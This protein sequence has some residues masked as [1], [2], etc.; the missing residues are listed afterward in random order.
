MFEPMWAYTDH[1]SIAAAAV[2]LF[3]DP[4]RRGCRCSGRMTSA[5]ASC[6]SRTDVIV[7]PMLGV[8]PFRKQVLAGLADDRPI[9]VGPLRRDGQGHDRSDRQRSTTPRFPAR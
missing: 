5:G 9:G 6:G 7:S 8:A 2:A 4:G 1:P 3:D